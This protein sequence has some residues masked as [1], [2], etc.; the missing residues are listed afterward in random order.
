VSKSANLLGAMALVVRLAGGEAQAADR[1]PDTM[2]ARV[3]K[4]GA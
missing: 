2:E 3:L 1:A 4:I